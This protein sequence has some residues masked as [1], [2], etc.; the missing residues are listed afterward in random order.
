M[1]ILKM[2]KNMKKIIL[3][4]LVALQLL[5]T[6]AGFLATP[7]RAEEEATAGPWYNQTFP[8]WYNKVYD[9][10][11]ADI[12][13]ERYTAAQVQ[14][15]IFGI[16]SLLINST[17]NPEIVTCLISGDINN[18]N[19]KEF[20]DKLA[21]PKFEARNK[22]S[23][24]YAFM[25]KDRPLSAVSYVKNTA[26]KFNIIPEAQAQ[27]GI[28]FNSLDPVLPLW[29]GV[30]NMAFGL[31][32]IATVALAFMIM[33]RVKISPQV[34]ITAQSA[35]PK[36]ALSI[37]LVT[38]SYAIAGLLVDLM[39]V[40]IG[41]IST[42]SSGIPLFGKIATFESLTVGPANTGI[43]GWIVLYAI[44]F[45]F[46]L[47]A[48]IFLSTNS[49]LGGLVLPFIMLFAL[50]A[51]IILFI[52]LFLSFFK[53]LWLLFRTF[54]N[55]LISTIFAPL[56]ITFGVLSP[57]SGFGA[58]IKGYISNLVIF[59]ITGTLFA[60]SLTLL[61][62]AISYLANNVSSPL[63][64]AIATIFGGTIPQPGDT[65]KGWPPLLG[66]SDGSIALAW[67]G[68]SLAVL[69]IIPKVNELVQSLLQGKPFA[70]GSAIG[71][72]VKDPLTLGRGLLSARVARHEEG[73]RGAM[74]DNY[75]EHPAT[76]FLKTVKIIN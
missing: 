29:R 64:V 32:V 16:A 11:N 10:E 30:R 25:S 65:S 57:S 14:W 45:S 35:L 44:F 53:I 73:R 51:I 63:S 50:I 48:S 12:F 58:W 61:L 38:F 49:V 66:S 9:K 68:A 7:I 8:Q 26:R 15:I 36:I 31:F 23:D 39:Y 33:F 55:I 47:L 76:K 43:F 52:M 21:L 1:I 60:L 62:S 24:F 54:A 75:A 42:M 37:I 41:L 74:G 6:S 13:G 46:T 59:P 17:N 3:S 22:S 67:I 2:I 28:G 5:I 27:T 40:F 19:I 72:A 70:Y 4:L 69:A 71:E 18:C 20:F 56:Q 34:I